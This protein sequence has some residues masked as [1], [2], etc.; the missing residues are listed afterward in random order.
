M[1]RR[2]LSSP[3]TCT[4]SR[5]WRSIV[6][7][8]FS[9]SWIVR[10]AMFFFFRF[11]LSI[12]LFVGAKVVVVAMVFS[13]IDR[14]LIK[15]RKKNVK[16][17]CEEGIC[18]LIF[19]ILKRGMLVHRNTVGLLGHMLLPP[20]LSRSSR[21]VGTHPLYRHTPVGLLGTHTPLN[22]HTPVDFV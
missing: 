22:C 11:G 6:R 8:V 10:Q 4:G 21:F 9:S 14:R 17:V 7:Y 13:M 19:N 2:C 18:S 1:T 15:C 5:K 12:Y 16:T 20:M 3:L